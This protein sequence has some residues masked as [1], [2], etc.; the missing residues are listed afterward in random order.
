MQM[1][2]EIRKMMLDTKKINKSSFLFT[3]PNRKEF[4]GSKS[5]LSE[6]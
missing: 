6:I 5:M 2:K 3:K 4:V 1:A